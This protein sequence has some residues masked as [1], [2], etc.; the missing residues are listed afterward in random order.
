MII[1]F[2]T[3]IL[4]FEGETMVEEGEVRKGKTGGSVVCYRG[5]WLPQVIIIVDI[6]VIVIV[7]R[8][9]D[10]VAS[11]LVDCPFAQHRTDT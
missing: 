9:G 5:A 1:I 11:V 8:W 6:I 2:I 3:M 4:I 10:M 7:L